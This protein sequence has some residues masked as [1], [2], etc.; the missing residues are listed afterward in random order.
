MV[1]NL[2]IL[3]CI[4]G[5]SV[6]SP[7][8]SPENGQY[9]LSHP[10]NLVLDGFEPDSVKTLSFVLD[11]ILTVKTIQIPEL[12][13]YTESNSRLPS[14]IIKLDEDT[15]MLYNAS[16]GRLEITYLIFRIPKDDA[17]YCIVDGVATATAVATATWFSPLTSFKSVKFYQNLSLL[18]EYVIDLSKLK[19]IV[20]GSSL[21]PGWKGEQVDQIERIEYEGLVLDVCKTGVILK[22]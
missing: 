21:V 10:T 18:A 11:G 9:L 15:E 16:R 14:K 19:Q 3:L 8:V 12:S 1:P 13:Y 6:K 20:H 4:D 17:V 5:V 22:Y 7:P 2:T